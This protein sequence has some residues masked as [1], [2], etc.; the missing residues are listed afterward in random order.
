MTTNKSI[1]WSAGGE[2]HDRYLL[3]K[4]FEEIVAG[5]DEH[6]KMC[7]ESALRTIRGATWQSAFTNVTFVHSIFES[8]TRGLHTETRFTLCA[9]ALEL[10]Y[11]CI[12][13]SLDAFDPRASYDRKLRVVFK[14]VYGWKIPE[15][16]AN[17]IRILRNDIMHTGSITGLDSSKKFSDYV[18]VIEK[19][20][21]E[22][23]DQS[24]EQKRF[25]V[26]AG[27]WHLADDMLARILGL[28]LDEHLSKSGVQPWA[29][30]LFGYEHGKTDITKL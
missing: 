14:A 10:I 22:L 25:Y 17:A 18:R 21:P 11:Y 29:N 16:T 19:R 7:T 26:I 4:L 13:E 2:A 9:Q 28:N 27:F 30:P 6:R 8:H 12:A 20:I 23:K 1:L 24:A 3:S 5:N 15:E